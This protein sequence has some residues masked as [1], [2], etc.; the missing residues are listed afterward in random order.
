MSKPKPLDTKLY[1]KVKNEI[2]NRVQVW[3]SAYASGLLVKEYKRRG[4]K[5]SG[6][7]SNNGNGIDRWFKEK[8]IDVCQLPKKVPCARSKGNKKYPY[9]RPTVKVNSKTPTTVKELSKKELEKRCKQKRKNPQKK[10]RPSKKS[11]A[12]KS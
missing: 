12:R 4:G 8:W 1:N 2:K 7:K 10:V 5:Y 6:T 9:C 11:R 3:P